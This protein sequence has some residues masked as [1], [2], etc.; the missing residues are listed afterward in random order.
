M[1][2]MKVSFDPDHAKAMEATKI[3]AALALPGDNTVDH[4]R[5]VHP[6]EWGRAV[7]QV[8]TRE[9]QQLVSHT[10][11]RVD[12]LP[13]VRDVRAVSVCGL[14]IQDLQRDLH[15]SER[16]TQFVCGVAKK[17]LL[18]GDHGIKTARHGVDRR[19][20]ASQFVA[21]RQ[22]HARRKPAV[23]DFCRGVFHAA[24]ALG[25]AA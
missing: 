25:E 5:H 10:A 1:I 9:L 11:Q 15:A 4:R 2:E 14:S 19:G 23:R 17:S 6:L 24:E 21:P 22:S 12:I 18:T 13:E 20:Q 7:R 3:W 16:R 8:C